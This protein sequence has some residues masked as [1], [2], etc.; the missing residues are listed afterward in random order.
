MWKKNRRQEN[1]WTVARQIQ[2]SWQILWTYEFDVEHWASWDLHNQAL[3]RYFWLE[4]YLVVHNLI[5][6]KEGK[7]LSQNLDLEDSTV[8]KRCMITNDSNLLNYGRY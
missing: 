3:L 4:D 7:T 6:K 1:V 5:W 8:I 2:C